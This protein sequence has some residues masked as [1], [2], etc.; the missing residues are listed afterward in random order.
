[1]VSFFG[2]CF[3][4]LSVLQN[5]EEG[6]REEAGVTSVSVDRKEVKR[7]GEG[8]EGRGGKE[9]WKGAVCVGDFVCVRVCEGVRVC[10]CVRVCVWVRE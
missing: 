3:F 9:R 10:V 2:R 8:G 1:M 5:P 7:R 4:C 6:R